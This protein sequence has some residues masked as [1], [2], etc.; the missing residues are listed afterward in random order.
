M[1]RGQTGDNLAPIRAGSGCLKSMN[2]PIEL[3]SGC[4]RWPPAAPKSVVPRQYSRLP[5]ESLADAAF[6]VTEPRRLGFPTTLTT[7]S[8]AT[9]P[10]LPVAISVRVVRNRLRLPVGLAP[11]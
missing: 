2:S 8:H 6:A 1:K 5:W 9:R 7:W 4:P 10:E 11:V 3:G